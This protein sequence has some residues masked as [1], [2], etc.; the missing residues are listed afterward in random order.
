MLKVN[1][2]E[3]AKNDK[4]AIDV[5]DDLRKTSHHCKQSA[6]LISHD[7]Q[8]EKS[9]ISFKNLCWHHRI[10][11]RKLFSFFASFSSVFV[12]ADTLF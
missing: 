9:Q 8:C 5:L 3:N 12:N 1:S 4:R 10:S 7:C 6:V 2:K 11:Q